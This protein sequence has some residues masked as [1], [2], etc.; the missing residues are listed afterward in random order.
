VPLDNDA[1]RTPATAHAQTL[2]ARLF[3]T[4]MPELSNIQTFEKLD[5]SDYKPTLDRFE[6]V[7]RRIGLWSNEV[8]N[9]F[10][11]FDWKVE[12][13]G[14]A[15]SSITQTGPFM[16]KFSDVKVRPLVM[17][18]TPAIDPSFKDNWMTC[19]LLI[20]AEDLRRGE[21]FEKSY[22]LVEALTYEMFREF[23]QTGVY[24]TDEAQD[25]QDFDGL[26]T[27]DKSKLWQ[28]DYALVP[29]TLRALYND[30]PSTHEVIERG[31]ALEI[32]NRAR[33]KKNPAANKVHNQWRGSV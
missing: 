22:D 9:E 26:R 11:G 30:N 16:T 10:K 28:F 21:Y 14:F 12:D 32:F 5:G 7:L 1:L 25:G 4:D 19:D 33:W 20:E 3:R 17:V 8:E 31:N 18:Y 6:S 2:A 29:L 15:Y 24:F 27:N 13:N 23:K